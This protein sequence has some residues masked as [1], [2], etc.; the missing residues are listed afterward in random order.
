MQQQLLN[1]QLDAGRLARPAAVRFEN[2]GPQDTSDQD[3]PVFH[4]DPQTS[5]DYYWHT[6]TD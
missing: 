2:S 5:S 3:T 6:N 1:Q 4:P